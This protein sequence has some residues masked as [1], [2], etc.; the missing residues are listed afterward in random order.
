MT[1]CVHGA[2]GMSKELKK[3]Q[4]YCTKES[5]RFNLVLGGLRIGGGDEWNNSFKSF[6][7]NEVA[8]Y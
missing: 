7:R 4:D 2:G 5:I 1:L 8:K 3:I 6:L